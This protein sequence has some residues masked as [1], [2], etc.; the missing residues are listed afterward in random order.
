[1]VKKNININVNNQSNI[2][3]SNLNSNLKILNDK[4]INK[5]KI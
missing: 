4:S 2:L 5:N 1:M 3:N